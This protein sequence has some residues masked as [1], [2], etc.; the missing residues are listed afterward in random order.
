MV[1]T[2]LGADGAVVGAAAR[3]A[4]CDPRSAVDEN[5]IVVP[6]RLTLWQ[7]LHGERV[8]GRRRHDE[9]RRLRRAERQPVGRP[10]GAGRRPVVEAAVHRLGRESHADRGRAEHAAAG[11]VGPLDRRLQRAVGVRVGDRQP[12]ARGQRSTDRSPPCTAR[13]S[14]SGS[15]PSSRR[16]RNTRLRVVAAAPLERDLAD[17]DRVHRP[18]ERVDDAAARRSRS[19][20]LAAELPGRVRDRGIDVGE[21]KRR[22]ARRLG[23]D[24]IA[25]RASRRRAR[26]SDACAVATIQRG[27]RRSSRGAVR[28]ATC[29]GARCSSRAARAAYELDG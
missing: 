16:M 9:R 21:W 26:S 10:A 20:A 27:A 5:E 1:G 22:R 7:P 29:C 3:N 28:R 8:G 13:R 23:R 14:R 24:P 6:S 2:M 17:V 11:A 4:T 15:L 25:A 19:P 18:V 12:A